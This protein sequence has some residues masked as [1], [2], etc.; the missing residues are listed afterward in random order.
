MTT[1]N[2]VQKIGIPHMRTSKGGAARNRHYMNGSVRQQSRRV[3]GRCTY[4][5]HTS[6]PDGGG[7]CQFKAAADTHLYE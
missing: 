1:I 5:G 7:G 3:G 4:A 2:M 6:V